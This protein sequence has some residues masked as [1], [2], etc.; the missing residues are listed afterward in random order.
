VRPVPHEHH[1]ERHSFES[2]DPAHQEIGDIHTKYE[3]MHDGPE[4]AGE[5]SPDEL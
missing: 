1:M 3:D 4:Y 2:A 5:V